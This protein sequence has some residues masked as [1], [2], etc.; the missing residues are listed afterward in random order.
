MV[1]GVKE[2]PRSEHKVKNRGNVGRKPAAL[3]INRQAQHKTREHRQKIDRSERQKGGAAAAF[4]NDI[5]SPKSRGS[6]REPDDDQE[7][8]DNQGRIRQNTAVPRLKTWQQRC[9]DDQRKWL[10]DDSNDE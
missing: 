6:S 1:A 9:F 10:R 8:G 7:L 4:R 2:E 5:P 3:A